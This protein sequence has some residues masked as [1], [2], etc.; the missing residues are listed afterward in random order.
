MDT[1]VLDETRRDRREGPPR[2]FLGGRIKGPDNL[3]QGDWRLNMPRFQG[4]NLH[5]NLEI[6]R[7]VESLAKKKKCTAAQLA[8]AWLLA[9]G[10]D[11]VPIPGTKRRSYL[12]ENVGAADVKLSPAEMHQLDEALK[13]EA[14]AGPRYNAQYQALVDR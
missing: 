1:L 13:P 5:R 12:E 2:G 8:L 6:A 3:E 4:E 9:Q 10:K 7:R 14:V 11:I